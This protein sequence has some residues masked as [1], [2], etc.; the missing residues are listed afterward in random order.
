MDT[1]ARRTTVR[2]T[3]RSAILGSAALTGA[4]LLPAAAHAAPRTGPVAADGQSA[5]QGRGKRHPW[6]RSRGPKRDLRDGNPASA[7]LDG[8]L[9][10][11]IPGIL[12]DGI[13]FDPARFSGATALVARKGRIAHRSAR[14]HALRWKTDTELLPDD[15]WIPTGTDTIYDLAS[16]SKIFTAVTVM[17]LVERGE[18]G[19]DDTIASYFPDFAQN[20]KE[21]LTVQQLLTHSSGLPA[22][23]NLFTD[24]L[25]DEEKVAKV[26]A[27]ELSNPPGTAYMYSDVGL[28]VL[29]LLVEHLTGQ[30][31]DEVVAERVTGPLGMTE[32]MYNPPQELLPR[33]A[34]T[35]ATGERGLVH[36][37]VHD[38]NAEALGGVAG[39]A[40]V[41]STADD[42]AIF[43]QMFLNG[44]THGGARVLQP[45]TVQAMF[46]D[47]IAEITGAG[48]ARRGLGPELEAWFYHSGLTSP[49]SGGHT[50]F[51]GTSLVIDPLTDTF[52]IML[53]NSVHPTREWSTTSVTR[54]EV[55]LCVARAVDLDPALTEAGWAAGT[56]DDATATLS[57]LVEIP[58]GIQEAARLE[59][60]IAHHLETT[61]DV[62]MV[63]ASADGGETWVGL[64]GALEAKGRRVQEIADGLV[65]GWGERV[66]WDGDF[67]IADGREPLTGEVEVR[68]RVVTD[69]AIHGLGVHLSR[70]RVTGAN[71]PLVDS[72]KEPGALVADGW[73]QTG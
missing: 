25:T 27:V 55:S 52:H 60:D 50:G 29:G 18:L 28:I 59:I 49:Y 54:R 22:G 57:A 7:G 41:F 36:G 51:T 35:E 32:T 43:A 6:D 44:G 31:L 9:L 67:R 8:A 53:A 12:Q 58:E 10:E 45:E 68:L 46:T 56:E 11:Q 4:V 48:G 5:A 63:E 15:Q 26:M 1:S 70:L 42:L 71:G 19:L 61:Y 34:A 65:T 30:G 62:L 47:H 38:E 17:Q 2:P 40:G 3:R 73:Q 39:H 72:R 16:I 14:G 64:N 37:V 23:V 20:G 24:P 21:S 13:D 69:E 66:R 33:I